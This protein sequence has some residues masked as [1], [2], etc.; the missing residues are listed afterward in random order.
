MKRILLDACVLYPTV[1]REILLGAAGAGL[2]QPLW[3]ARILEEWARAVARNLPDQADVA[4]VEIALLRAGWPDAEV[5]PDPALEAELY[6]PDQSDLHVLAAAISG[7]AE[8]LLTLNRGDFPTRTL[9]AR[10]ILRRD[11]YWLIMDFWHDQPQPVAAV[12]EAVRARAELLSGQP[13]E[14]RALLKKAGL[15]R[16]GKVLA[17]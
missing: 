10:G 15:P 6:L 11:P 12:C 9:G 1:M 17:R 4:R 7:N 8:I 2:F 5:V 16:L 13:Q 14:I 3:S